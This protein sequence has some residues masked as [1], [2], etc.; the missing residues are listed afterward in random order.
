MDPAACG[1]SGIRGIRGSSALR[2]A[3]CPWR[4]VG[5]QREQRSV[6]SPGPRISAA[7]TRTSSEGRADA[8]TKKC[9]GTS[10]QGRPRYGSFEWSFISRGCAKSSVGLGSL[11]AGF[12]GFGSY[13]L[14]DPRRLAVF[15]D[16]ARR[17]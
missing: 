1:G 12:C 13:R 3:R 9:E 8:S 6:F 4:Y 16:A 5:S 14:R 2:R 11:G 7:E 10:S 17:C 15:R